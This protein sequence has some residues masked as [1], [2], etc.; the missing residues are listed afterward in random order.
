MSLVIDF[1]GERF[2][3]FDNFITA[4]VKSDDLAVKISNRDLYAKMQNA[5]LKLDITD[6][7]DTT[8]NLSIACDFNMSYLTAYL[9]TISLVSSSPSG[10]FY[11]LPSQRSENSSI[12]NVWFESSFFDANMGKYYS[13]KGDTVS[14][15]GSIDQ[16]KGQDNVILALEPH[17]NIYLSNAETVVP[18]Q[19]YPIN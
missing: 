18:N 7:R 13:L 2:A 1:P 14:I 6:F 8:N 12:I 3:F 5:N 17:L 16:D 19:K 4:V 11:M 10:I 15:E 9:D